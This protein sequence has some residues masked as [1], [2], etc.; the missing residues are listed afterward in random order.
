MSQEFVKVFQ[1]VSAFELPSRLCAHLLHTAEKKNTDEDVN[2][3]MDANRKIDP[4]FG[5]RSQSS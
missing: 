1:D 5:K 3:F 4:N 2:V